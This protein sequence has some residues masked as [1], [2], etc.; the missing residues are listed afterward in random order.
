MKAVRVLTPGPVGVGTR[1]EATVR[2][3]G[4]TTIDPVTVTQFEPPTRFAIAHEGSFTGS[5]LIT[6][7]SGADGTTT[8]LRW[9]ETLIAPALPHVAA[10]A[11]APVL[12]SIFQGDLLR[13]RDLIEGEARAASVGAHR[14]TT[15]T[16][17]RQPSETGST[18]S[19]PARPS[20]PRAASPRRRDLRAVP[21]PF[22]AAAT[23]P[24]TGRHP[25]VGRLGPVRPAAVPAPRGGRDARR[26][27][28]GP[29]HRILS[30]RPV[31]RLQVVGRHAARAARPVPD[32]RGGRRGARDRPVADGRI[33]GR[34]RDRD[35]GLALRR[36]P[37]GRKDRR[38]HPGQGHG[39]ACRRQADRPL[40]P[41]PAHRVRRRRCP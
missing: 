8:I 35:G 9:E 2:V 31:P 41:P 1:G 30:E 23:R 27:R 29:G 10:A 4:I 22:R 38:L 24:R 14:A 11:M 37:S 13:L 28:D 19:R 33:R 20:D 34:R 7:E 40:G 5:G 6:L 16:P 25:A 15:P 21:R 36:R 32:R 18:T 26:V 3:L 17:R 39:P 12:R